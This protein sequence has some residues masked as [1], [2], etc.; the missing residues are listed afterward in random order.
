MKTIDTLVEDIYKEVLERGGWDKA[1]NDY[2]KESVGKTAWDRFGPSTRSSGTL[3][4]SS[5]G[6]PCERRLWYGIHKEGKGEPLRAPSLIKF[7][8]GDLIED[9]ILSLAIAAGHKVEG[10]Q[11]E[12]DIK[13]VKG[14][15]DAVIDGVTVD[16]KS[17]SPYSFK[18]FA[19]GELEKDDPFGYMWQLTSYVHAAKDSRS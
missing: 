12:M 10:R 18:K 4:M 1:V 8:Y 2:Y 3:R 19:S 14:H 15:R 16:V 11:D 5:I 9:L 17:A 7:A 13:G 6:Q